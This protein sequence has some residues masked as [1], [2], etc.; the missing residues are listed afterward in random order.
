M[1]DQRRTG[2]EADPGVLNDERILAKTLV[3]ERVR[4]DE[5]VVLLD[6]VCAKGDAARGFRRADADP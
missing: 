2:I 3:Y 4:N 6:R 5:E 1:G